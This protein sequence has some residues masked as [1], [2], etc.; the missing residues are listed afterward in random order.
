MRNFNVSTK[1]SVDNNNDY[2]IA[3]L[4][5]HIESF[6]NKC[7]NPLEVITLFIDA[8]K[9]NKNKLNI[10]ITTCPAYADMLDSKF[11]YNSLINN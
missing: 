11:V 5:R 9:E 6:A 8:Y 2:A 1:Y 10:K 3:K 4:F 7:K